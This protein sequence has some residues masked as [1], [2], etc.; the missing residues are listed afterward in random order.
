[1]SADIMHHGHLIIINETTKPGKIII[2]NIKG[3]DEVVPQEILDFLPNLRKK[4]DY[5]VHRDD[6]GNSVQ[7][8]INPHSWDRF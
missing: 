4:P 3:V 7:K 1:M 6:W 2:E 5:V 8:V